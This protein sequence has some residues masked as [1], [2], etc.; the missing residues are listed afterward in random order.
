MGGKSGEMRYIIII[1]H[2][3]GGDNEN[4][5]YYVW[6]D[7]NDVAHC[8]ESKIEARKA[9]RESGLHKFHVGRIV[10]VTA[11]NCEWI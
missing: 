9:W 6:A 4:S 10:E 7:E 5:V 1:W 8:F 11:Q 3:A 2:Q